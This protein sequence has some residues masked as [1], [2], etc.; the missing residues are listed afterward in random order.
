[1][2]ENNSILGNRGEERRGEGQRRKK[3]TRE[4][5]EIL[6]KVKR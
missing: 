3:K 4:E 5:E 2:G 1:M 6:T